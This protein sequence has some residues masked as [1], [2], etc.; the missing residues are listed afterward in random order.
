M[1]DDDLLE[2]AFNEALKQL[3]IET[4]MVQKIQSELDAL[5]RA[6]L[7]HLELKH[8]YQTMLENNAPAWQAMQKR[9]MD[10]EKQMKG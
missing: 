8:K 4:E 5:D 1:M 10:R 3:G 2:L 9:K 7:I 6:L